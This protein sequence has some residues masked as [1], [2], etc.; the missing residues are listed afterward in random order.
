MNSL[1]LAHAVDPSSIDPRV[2]QGGMTEE[3]QYFLHP[4]KLGSSRYFASAQVASFGI[5]SRRQAIWPSLAQT[6]IGA[7]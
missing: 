4:R 6:G 5:S 3:N 1:E 2:F 7:W